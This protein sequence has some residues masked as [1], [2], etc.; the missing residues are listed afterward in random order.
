[1][2]FNIVVDMLAILIVWAKEDGQVRGLIPHPVEGGESSLQ[3]ADDTIL[4]MEHEFEKEMKMKLNLCI[5]LADIRLKNRFI[6]VR[7]YVL[8]KQK[9]MRM[10]I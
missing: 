8:V 7:F 2:L 1:M 9:K 10:V 3:Y 5:F 4:F 6:R